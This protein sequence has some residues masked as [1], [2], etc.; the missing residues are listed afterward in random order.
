MS[1]RVHPDPQEPAGGFAF[2]ELA[3]GSLP[4]DAVSVAVFDAFGERWLARPDDMADLAQDEDTRWQSE[5]VDFGPYKVYR[6]DG[7][8][9]VRIGPE[10]VDRLEEYAPLRITVAGRAHDVIW[11]DNVPPRASAAVRGGLQPVGHKVEPLIDRRVGVVEAPADVAVE[12]GVP[13]INEVVEAEPIEEEAPTRSKGRFL[14]PLLLLLAVLAAVVLWY[15]WPASQSDPEPAPVAQ[16]EPCSRAT[17]AATGGGFAMVLE[18][19]RSCGADVQ[20]DTALS[21]VEEAAESDDADALLLFGTLYDGEALDPR[22][23]NLTGL[24]FED[25][26]AQAADYYA[27][28]LKAGSSEAEG[29]LSDICDRL[30]QSDATLS[31]GAYDD[32]CS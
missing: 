22:I 14:A 18:A 27:R 20:A 11:P 12:P 28:A 23:E 32:F 13:E 25:D 9:W 3:A 4:V 26:P 10:I 19:I 24:T 8:D 1:L 21:L 2:L 7:A 6:H 15:F 5:P 16:S 17:L 31:I 29:R 30:E